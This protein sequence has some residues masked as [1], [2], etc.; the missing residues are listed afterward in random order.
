MTLKAHVLDDTLRSWTDKTTGNQ[1]TIRN[2]C[3]TDMDPARRYLKPVNIGIAM[4]DP[5]AG[6]GG[7]TSLRDMMVTVSIHS[8]EVLPWSKTGEIG[9]R[10]DLLSVGGNFVEQP[11]V[12]QAGGKKA[13]N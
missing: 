10:A 11:V 5:I 1:K 3:L 13:G 12:P 7:Q 4:D 6:P 8:I 2:L 9:F